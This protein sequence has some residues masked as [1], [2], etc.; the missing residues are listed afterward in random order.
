[1]AAWVIIVFNSHRKRFHFIQHSSCPY[2]QS[3]REDI[4]HFLL[5][6]TG[7]AAPRGD[8][9]G[10]LGLLLPQHNHLFLNPTKP[11]HQKEL[12]KLMLY[13][14]NEVEVDSK[15]YKIV[16][17]YIETTKRFEYNQ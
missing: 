14:I 9:F 11:K 10:Q 13:G 8:M 4:P 15:I 12:C 3:R 16:A 2:C 17:R 1:M 6:C 5:L 7:H